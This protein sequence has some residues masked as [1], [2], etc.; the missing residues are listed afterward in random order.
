VLCLVV[1]LALQVGSNLAND[2]SDG[3][4]GA[5]R[6]RKGPERLVASGA[7]TPGSVRA[8]AFAAFGLACLAGLGLCWLT[9]QWWLVAV[10]AAAVA[11]AWFYTGGARPYGYMALGE[12]GV[13][14]FFGPVAVLGTCY[15]QHLG[16]TW[17]AAVASIGVGL[18][19][20]AIL[21]ANNLRDLRAD[22][23][24][25]KITVA[26][27]LGEAKARSL[28]AWEMWLALVA[29]AVCAIGRPRI[30]VVLLMAVPTARLTSAV[31][32][33]LSGQ[34]LVRALTRTGQVELG[35]SILMG[36]ALADLGLFSP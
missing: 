15:T 36:L 35:Y 34:D 21:M 14:V 8:A 5:D 3:V 23:A 33:G 26:V 17:R 19:A 16:I 28:Y 31:G 30:L 24:V 20:C 4:R 1:A 7:A 6:D 13:F 27:K 9:G 2:Y 10:G 29:A 12:A 18:L 25:G 32:A 11:A 22:K